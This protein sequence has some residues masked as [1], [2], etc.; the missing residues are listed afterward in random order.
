MVVS[1]EENIRLPFT[2][3]SDK[4]WQYIRNK[5]AGA[6]RA[7]LGG[8]LWTS[9]TT[10]QYTCIALHTEP[11]NGQ[12]LAVGFAGRGPRRSTLGQFFNF[13]V[14]FIIIFCLTIYVKIKK[15]CIRKLRLGML[16]AIFHIP[17][18]IKKILS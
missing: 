7:E 12:G 13:K 11:T 5:S 3:D 1:A 15:F 17:S 9:S 10:V 16:N 18:K 8:G 4:Y 2:Q 14:V 6:G